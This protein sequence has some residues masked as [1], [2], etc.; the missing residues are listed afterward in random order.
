MPEIIVW[1]TSVRRAL[2]DKHHW[3]THKMTGSLQ[4]PLQPAW[5]ALL[6]IRPANCQKLL[7]RA[8]T[9]MCLYMGGPSL[10][11]RNA[12]RSSAELIK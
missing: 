4:S 7:P 8:L 2:S 11:Y 12:Y 1:I 10:C 9:P 6:A 3:E 5:P